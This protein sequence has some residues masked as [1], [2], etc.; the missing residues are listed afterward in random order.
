MVEEDLKPCTAEQYECVSGECIAKDAKCDGKTDCPD[1]SDEALC[2]PVDG[3]NPVTC[4]SHFI[5][6]PVCFPQ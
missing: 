4:K 3:I 6:L 1:G 2:A 5:A